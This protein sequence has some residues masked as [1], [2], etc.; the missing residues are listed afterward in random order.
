MST[1][2]ISIF[3]PTIKRKDMNSVLRCLVEERLGP[4]SYADELASSLADYVGAA[5][6]V[7]FREISRAVESVLLSLDAAAGSSIVMSALSPSIYFASVKAAGFEPLVVDVDAKSGCLE[8]AEVAKVVDRG[9]A[10][11]LVHSPLGFVPEMEKLVN[12]SVPIIEDFSSCFGA[13]AGGKVCG[14]FGSYSILSME[15]DCIITSAGG[16]V[17]LCRTR[18]ELGELKKSIENLDAGCFLPNMNAALALTQLRSIDEYLQ[19]RSEIARVYYNSLSRSG[20]KPFTQQGDGENVHY[21][22]PVLLNGSLR[23]A[24]KYAKAKHIETRAAFADAVI[25]LPGLNEQDYPN[26][27]ALSLRSIIFPLYPM[28]SRE[29]VLQV[30]KVLSTLP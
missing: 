18:R 16:V 26:A 2:T 1:E 30:S 3:K 11:I 14:S 7:A 9:P 12:F 17:V 29:Q 8:A 27:R 23:D 22:F 13:Y 21:S 19:K 4:G 10:A 6:G 25:G 24:A 15:E 20:H 5:G 28:L